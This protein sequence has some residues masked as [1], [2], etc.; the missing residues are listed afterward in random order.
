MFIVSN[1]FY[2]LLEGGLLVNGRGDPRVEKLCC[3]VVGVCWCIGASVGFTSAIKEFIDI[4]WESD[5]LAQ[6][7]AVLIW[8]SLASML[9][10]SFIYAKRIIHVLLEHKLKDRKRQ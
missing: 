7:T 2:Q 6:E 8:I 1:V 3:S 4:N 10:I 9:I 5:S